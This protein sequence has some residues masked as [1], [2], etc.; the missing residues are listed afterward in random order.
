M[1]DSGLKKTIRQFV[2]PPFL[3]GHHNPNGFFLFLS[4]AV[5]L[6]SPFKI[7][8]SAREK[9]KNSFLWMLVCCCCVCVGDFFERGCCYQLVLRL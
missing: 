3:D 4:S 9:K 5:L 8:L 6:Y 7:S 2:F 1:C